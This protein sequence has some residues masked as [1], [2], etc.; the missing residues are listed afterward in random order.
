[1]KHAISVFAC[2]CLL[3]PASLFAQWEPD[4]RLS[5]NDTAISYN[6]YTRAVATGPQDMVHSVWHDARDN[7]GGTGVEVYYRRSVDDG[8]TWQ[9]DIR[10]TNYIPQSAAYPA[11][12]RSGSVIHVTWHVVSPGPYY[13]CY[14]IRSTDGGTTWSEDTC[15]TNNNSSSNTH[16]S[17]AGSDVHMVSQNSTTGSAEVYYIRSTNEGL[18]WLPEIRLSSNDYKNSFWPVVSTSGSNVHVAWTDM[19]HSNVCEIYYIRSTDSG[20]TWGTE[21]LISTIDTPTQTASQYSSI[22]VSG[23]YVHIAWQD[24]YHVSGQPAGIFYRRSTNE[25]LSWQPVR[26][27]GADSHN[28]NPSNYPGFPSICA[29]STNVHVVWRDHRDMYDQWHEPTEIYYKHS[30]DNGV[31]WSYDTRLTYEL[32]FKALQPSMAVSNEAVHV[33]WFD[34]RDESGKYEMYYKRNPTINIG[35]QEEKSLTYLS[36]EPNT[37]KAMPNPFVSFTTVPGHEDESFI[38]YDISGRQCGIHNGARIGEMIPAGVYFIRSQTKD[39]TPLR[40]LKIK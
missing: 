10:L 27:L 9:Q 34:L 36:S 40:I 17:A 29:S 13:K 39:F 15:L 21:I 8:A 11:I 23:S 32:P 14:Y 37:L 22:A 25:G 16:V 35:I 1:M 19:R 24:L 2:F 33:V 5:P 26:I 38:L 12:A 18:T 7:G 28:T 6:L 4:M 3:I 31:T 20:V 30:T